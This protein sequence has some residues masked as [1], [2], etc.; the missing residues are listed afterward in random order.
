[1]KMNGS[2]INDPFIFIVA[3]TLHL[4]LLLRV[5]RSDT[6]LKAGAYNRGLA[7]I[8]LVQYFSDSRVDIT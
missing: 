1:M 8:M 4:N 7:W 5:L 6:T 3:F 2:L